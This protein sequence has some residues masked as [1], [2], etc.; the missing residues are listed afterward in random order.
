[1]YF[2]GATN[3]LGHEIGAIMISPKK[4]Y[5]P[6][7]ARL[8][9]NYTNNITEY[10]ACIMGLQATTARRVKALKVFGDSTLVIYQLKEK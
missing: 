8:N 3:V 9:F 7:T 6:V 4:Q 1:M 5:C 2:D 10:E